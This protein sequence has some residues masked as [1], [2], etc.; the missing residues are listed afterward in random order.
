ML[1]QGNHS[2]VPQ[3]SYFNTLVTVAEMKAQLN[4]TTDDDDTLLQSLITTA[5]DMAGEYCWRLFGNTGSFILTLKDWPET[6][7]IY[8]PVNPVKSVTSVKYYDIT[9][10]QQT[11][12]A[13]TDYIAETG[14]EPAC[15]TMINT[16]GLYEYRA[17][18]ILITYVAGYAAVGDI[19]ATVKQAIIMQ[20]ATMY[21]ERTN[22]SIA[23]SVTPMSV[24]TERLLAPH[25]NRLWA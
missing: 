21:E 16:P 15:I 22:D 25:R 5:I 20:A 12:V 1:L 19:P 10:T 23:S 2:R 3:P 4:L 17:W 7:P 24:T 14:T 6:E 8:L 9:G 11:L 18:P 13:G